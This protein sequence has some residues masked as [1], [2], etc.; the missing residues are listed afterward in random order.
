MEAD[1]ILLAMGYLRPVHTG[2]LEGL[3]VAFDKRG[4]VDANDKDYRTSVDKVFVAGDSRR[5]SR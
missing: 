5:G 4:N 2:L 1:L 3:G